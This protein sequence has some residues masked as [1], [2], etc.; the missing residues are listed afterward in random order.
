MR[1]V[2]RADAARADGRAQRPMVLRRSVLHGGPEEDRRP[3]E[4]SAG[5]LRRGAPVVTKLKVHW[6][7]HVFDY[8]HHGPQTWPWWR[9]VSFSWVKA[10][11]AAPST[12]YHW[13]IYTRW[14]ALMAGFYFDRRNLA[15][16]RRE[17]K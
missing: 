5:P 16:K 17:T 15:A 10:S 12:G 13:W 4:A 1:R 3:I 6:P 8:T 2:R 11:V 9:L 14:G 7:N